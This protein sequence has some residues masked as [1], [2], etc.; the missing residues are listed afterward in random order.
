MKSNSTKCKEMKRNAKIVE[1]MKC[2]DTKTNYK[3]AKKCK[4]MQEMQRPWRN[5]KTTNKSPQQKNA[6]KCDE[7]SEI[8]TQMKKIKEIQGNIGNIKQ[9]EQI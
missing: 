1:E 2:K 4:A 9:N 7:I 5:G 8:Q 3:N 6:K